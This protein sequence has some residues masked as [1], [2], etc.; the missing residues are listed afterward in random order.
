MKTKTKNKLY[1][2]ETLNR[3]AVENNWGRVFGEETM[4][5]MLKNAPDEKTFIE[6]INFELNDY[7]TMKTIQIEADEDTKALLKYAG[8]KRVHSGWYTVKY[9]GV[10]LDLSTVKSAK[11]NPKGEIIQWSV[12]TVIKL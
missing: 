12:H 4:L 9:N 10:A 5:R 6:D 8:V 3:I 11:R 2:D 7:W 1:Q